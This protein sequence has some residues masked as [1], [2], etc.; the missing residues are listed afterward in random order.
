[1]A[2]VVPGTGAP[3]SLEGLEEALE[4]FGRYDRAGVRDGHEGVAVVG[5]GSDVDLS[6]KMTDSYAFGDVNP[7][8]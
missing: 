1:M 4:L 7:D 8:S 5:A 3:E 2:V 6:S